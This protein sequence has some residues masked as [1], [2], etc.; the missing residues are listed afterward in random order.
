MIKQT[1]IALT[2]LAL[3]AGCSS[4]PNSA[5][6]VDVLSAEE[7]AERFEEEV[8]DIVPDPEPQFNGPQ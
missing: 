8:I 1:L 7:V 4:A 5:V 6:E 3:I 2:S